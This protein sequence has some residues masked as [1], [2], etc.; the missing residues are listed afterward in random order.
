MK[1]AHYY[2]LYDE[3]CSLCRWYTNT[4]VRYGFLQ[5][6]AR[7]PFHK[8]I[9]DARFSF[10]EDRARTEIAL[11]SDQD[12][13][14]RYGID[15]LL[16]ILG[17]RWKWVELIGHFAPIHFL[18][19][20]LYKVISWNRKVIAPV[21]CTT[22][23]RCEPPLNRFWRLVFI[24]LCG[25][26]TYVLVGSYFTAYFQ[27]NL[28]WQTPGLEGGLFLV[29]IGFQFLFFR[30]FRQRD[31]WMYAG[32]IAVV[33]AIGALVLGLALLGL[34]LLSSAGL[35]VQFLEQTTFGLVLGIMLLEHARRVR[36]LGLTKWLTVTWFIFRLAIYPLIFIL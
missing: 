5:S 31:F 28:R 10:D 23:C 3:D 12:Q 1:T 36:M 15:S 24:L 19:R 34:N 6:D 25:S 16:F 7:M 32:Q 35:D 17:R 14:V 20:M 22:D 21:T 13:P 4:F 8:G 11:V 9:Q 27:E 30:V 18:L 2:L 29:Q 33:S 26:L